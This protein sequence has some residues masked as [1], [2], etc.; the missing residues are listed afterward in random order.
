MKSFALIVDNDLFTQRVLTLELAKY[1]LETV[2]ASC[3]KEGYRRFIELSPKVIFIEILIPKHGGLSLL[4]RIRSARDGENLP[5]FMLSMLKNASIRS[6]AIMG[7]HAT[8]Y[9]LKP[10]QTEKISRRLKRIFDEKAD[11]PVL[12]DPFD[13]KLVSDHGSLEAVD[14]AVLLKKLALKSATACINFNNGKTK[15]IICMR[16]GDITFALSNRLSETLGR[17]LVS[18]GKIDEST[19]RDG[20]IITQKTGLKMGEFLVSAGLLSR[21]EMRAAVRNNVLEK[22]LELFRWSGGN[23]SISP[24]RKPPAELPGRPFY[25]REVLWNGIKERLPLSRIE[26]ALSPFENHAIRTKKNLLNLTADASLDGN[27]R[28]FLNKLRQAASGSAAESIVREAREEQQKRLLYYLFI[29]DYFSIFKKSEDLEQEVSDKE[30]SNSAKPLLFAAEERLSTWRNFNFFQILEVPINASDNKIRDAYRKKAK[31]FHPD[32][33]TEE[34]QNEVKPLY[35]EL[36]RLLNE[37]YEG[38]KTE[39]RRMAYLVK[40]EERAESKDNFVVEDVLAAEILFKKG[41]MHLLKRQWIDAEQAFAQALE[42]NPEEGAYALGLGKAKLHQGAAGNA[43]VFPEAEDMLKKAAELTPK[44]ADPIFFLGRLEALKGNAEE[45][46]CFFR[47]ALDINENHLEA[48]RELRLMA[49]RAE[50]K[51]RAV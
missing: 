50:K 41:E 11:S 14:I 17:H 51:G 6:E 22:I 33:L 46:E 37:A 45:A 30:K 1:G 21:D 43:A 49:M 34:N 44:E 23:Y 40:I 35:N 5:V 4:R 27:D 2:S 13:L 15:K 31:Q 47:K 25:A 38:L 20:H 10:I 42:L 7:L 9:I 19:A 48:Q 28:I 32:C 36:F 3:D 8:D 39:D 16:D 26:N 24:Y 12:A 29:E 18:K